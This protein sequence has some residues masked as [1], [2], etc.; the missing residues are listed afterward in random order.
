MFELLGLKISNAFT[1][2]RIKFNNW[3]N[4][5]GFVFPEP[6]PFTIYFYNYCKRILEED[7]NH[8]EAYEEKIQENATKFGWDRI[9][10]IQEFISVYS[11][12]YKELD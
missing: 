9:R 4:G 2:F 7:T 3:I 12:L 5:N 8:I 10:T 6:D 11:E 1:M